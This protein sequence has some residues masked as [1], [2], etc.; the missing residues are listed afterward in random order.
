MASK[1][2]FNL[3]HSLKREALGPDKLHTMSVMVDMKR[4]SPTVPSQRNI[5][6]FSNAP[7]FAELL[8]LAGSDAFFINT[9][10]LEYGGKPDELKPCVKALQTLRPKRPPACVLKDIIIH[11]VQIAQALENGAS[12][13]LLIVAVVGGDLEVLLDACTIMG[14]EALVEVHTPNELEYALSRGATT[15]LVNL[16]DRS[17]LKFYPNQVR[18]F[19][20]VTGS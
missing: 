14:T 13:V 18:L 17:S 2:N 16:W 3:T 12:G 9:E 6:E 10:E 7:K 19:D 5:V 1:C 11:P 8:T 15:F 20:S 4:K